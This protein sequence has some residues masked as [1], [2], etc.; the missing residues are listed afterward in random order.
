MKFKLPKNIRI[1][2]TFNGD[3]ISI[4][5]CAFEEKA[6]KAKGKGSYKDNIEVVLER[7][8]ELH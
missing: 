2:F 4:L 1:L 3:G 6:D 7:I 5:L 8:K